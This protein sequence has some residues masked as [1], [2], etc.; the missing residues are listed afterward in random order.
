VP[1]L[2]EVLPETRSAA[3]RCLEWT[4]CPADG[5]C[6]C[7]AVMELI[8]AK[9]AG[10]KPRVS[11]YSVVEFKPGKDYSGRAFRLTKSKTHEVRHVLYDAADPANCS[12]DCEGWTFD[13]TRKA[14]TRDGFRFSESLGCAH[15]DGIA[16]ADANGWLPHPNE[17]PA[18]SEPAGQPEELDEHVEAIGVA[19]VGGYGVCPACRERQAF[20][21]PTTGEVMCLACY[22]CF[23]PGTEVERAADLMAAGAAYPD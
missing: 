3:Y 17:R 6:A 12:C 19:S 11:R 22:E 8:Q 1:I 10:N 23:P 18:E 15:L 7:T 20:V 13:G 5:G 2:T 9:K 16:A 4:P 21:A 14:D